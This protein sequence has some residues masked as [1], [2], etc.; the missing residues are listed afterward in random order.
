MVVVVPGGSS[1]KIEELFSVYISTPGESAVNQNN[2]W[3]ANM[4]I[5]GVATIHICVKLQCVLAL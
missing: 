2:A 3:K 5:K 4:D 1:N